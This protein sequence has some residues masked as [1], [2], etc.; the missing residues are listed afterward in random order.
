MLLRKN[1][2]FRKS[3]R[4]KQSSSTLFLQKQYL[5]INKIVQKYF[6]VVFAF[7]K[8]GKGYF[9]LNTNLLL[10]DLLWCPKTIQWASEG[11]FFEYIA[12]VL[13]WRGGGRTVPTIC[14]ILLLSRKTWDVLMDA[15]WRTLTDFSSVINQFSPW[16]GI[17]VRELCSKG[18]GTQDLHSIFFLWIKKKTADNW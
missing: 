2:K 15:C 10:F 5:L 14:A 8:K 12:N 6:F 4:E 13:I 17:P 9:R 7:R 16:S 18:S 1:S 3:F 11:S